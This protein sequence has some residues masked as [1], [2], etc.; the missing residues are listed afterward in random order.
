MF[1]GDKKILAKFSFFFTRSSIEFNE[2]HILAKLRDLSM[3][4]T[5]SESACESLVNFIDV[6]IYKAELK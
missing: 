2:D 1:S 6:M 3:N 5:Q 4:L